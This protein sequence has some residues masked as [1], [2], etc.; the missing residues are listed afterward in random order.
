MSFNLVDSVKSMFTN[1]VTTKLASS[2]GESEGGIQKAIGGSIPAVL[3]GLLNKAGTSEGASSILNLSKEAAGSG[4]LSNLAGFAGGG[5]SFI[6]K[7]LDW[8]RRLFGDK[9][10]HLTSLIAGFAGIRESSASS[11]LS[12]A[13]P[14]ALGT[15]G[16]QVTQ[17]NLGVSGL[18]SLL[19]SQKDSILSALPSGLN[20]A[21][22]LGLGS[23]SDLGSRL[24]GTYSNAATTARATA[25]QTTRRGNRWVMPLI[26]ALIAIGALYYLIKGCNNQAEDVGVIPAADTLPTNTAVETPAMASIK[27]VL[28][29]GVE[30]DAY[31][32]GI[33]DRL[34]AFLNDPASQGGKDVW[35]DF[36]NLNFETGSATLTAESMKQVNNIAAILK[37]YPKLKIKIGGYT[38]KSGDA[39]VNKK[40]SQ[41]RADATLGALRNT[42]AN[43]AQLTG[44][45]G[46]GS[47]FATVAADAPDGERRKDRRIAVGV[48]EK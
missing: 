3:A 9:V 38:D 31:K 47:E 43:G 34:V 40:L 15:L 41:D 10:D 46:Y 23:L 37:A 19:A 39:A 29:D 5:S 45:E 33:E 17:Q 30:L 28:P 13:A 22:A 44:A 21:G 48:R 8:L 6:G 2:F 14:A 20:L 16:N 26:L 27:V 18:T 4:L 12:V 35:F 1:D 25:A 42:G 32:G 36:D 11:V 24:T 7:G